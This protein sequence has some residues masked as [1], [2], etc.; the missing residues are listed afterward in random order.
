MRVPI[1]ITP[2]KTILLVGEE[3]QFVLQHRRLQR[4]KMIWVPFSNHPT[5]ESALNK[6]FNMKVAMSQAKSLLGLRQVCVQVRK[7]IRQAFVDAG[8]MDDKGKVQ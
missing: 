2:K 4:G 5:L 7:E 1:A 3:R 6:I 8:E